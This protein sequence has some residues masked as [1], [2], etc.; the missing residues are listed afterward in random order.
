MRMIDNLRFSVSATTRAR[1]YDEENGVDYF[2][3]S[4]EDFLNLA[5]EGKLVEYE[6]VYPGRFYGTLKTELDAASTES[7]VLLDIDVRGAV[8]IKEAYGDDALVLF[9]APPS[10]EELESRLRSRGT[11]D[12]QTLSVRMSRS[13]K[14]MDY[15]DRFDAIVINDD[16]DRAAEETVEH[17]SSFLSLS[18]SKIG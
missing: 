4:E 5:Q 2:F 17:I 7:P 8:H 16:L 9:I 6:E 11:E 14:E 13:A 15:A 18:G 1:R 12:E 10:M 3:L